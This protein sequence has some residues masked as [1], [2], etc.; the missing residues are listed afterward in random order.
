MDGLRYEYEELRGVQMYVL[1][2]WA[3]RGW[4]V[5]AATYIASQVGVGTSGWC[6]LLERPV[7]DA[8]GK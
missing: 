2:G 3:A 6:V 4:R 1:S 7:R 8:M 5:V